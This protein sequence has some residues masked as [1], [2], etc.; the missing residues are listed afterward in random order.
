[1]NK[2][3]KIS[4][5]EKNYLEKNVENRQTYTEHNTLSHKHVHK[6]KRSSGHL[7]TKPKFGQRPNLSDQLGT[8]RNST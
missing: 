1:M 6:M 2:Y 8:K 7:E 4:A 5:R 3:Y